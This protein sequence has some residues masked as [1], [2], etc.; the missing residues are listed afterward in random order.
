MNCFNDFIVDLSKLRSNA[1]KVKEYIG[2]KCKFCAVVK[3]N[4]YGVGIDA[5]CKGLRGVA[6]FFAVACLKEALRIRRFDKTTPI[7]ILGYIGQNDYEI[8]SRH[9]ISISVGDFATLEYLVM[10]NQYKINI[11]IQVNTGLNRFGFRSISE[12]SKAIKM[13]DN[14]QYLNLEGVYSHFATKSRD[15]GFI[16]KQY[17]RFMQFKKKVSR[18]SVIFHISNSYATTLNKYCLDMV[19][20]GYLLYGYEDKNLVLDNVLTVKSKIINI[21]KVKRGDSIGYDRTFI[22]KKSMTIAV[23][24]IG[25]ADGY[26][27]LLSNKG[28]VIH[29]EKKLHIVGLICMDV[30]MVDVTGQNVSIGDVVTLIGGS[31]ESRVA[32]S[33]LA[34]L[35]NMSP[36]EFMCNL[37]YKRMNYI[38]K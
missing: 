29:S 2:D 28:Y 34:R 31:G 19:R 5:V 9:N 37:N 17:L 12:F 38:I 21:L 35:I 26:N 23:I 16:K 8:A 13:I 25:Y 20:V 10:H 4:A 32:I 7:L 6:D 3:A 15:V 14:N 27:R 33:D 18:D 24:P 1:V 22:A 11:H 36:Y 30:L